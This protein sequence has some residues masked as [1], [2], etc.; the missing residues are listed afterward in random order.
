MNIIIIIIIIIIARHAKSFF[1]CGK[2]WLVNNGKNQALVFL[3]Q[4]ETPFLFIIFFNV[5]HY[6]GKFLFPWD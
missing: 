1:L 4:E 6:L 3:S 5:Y 2:W